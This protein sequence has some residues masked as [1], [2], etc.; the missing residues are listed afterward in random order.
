M[1]VPKSAL[2]AVDGTQYRFIP[3]SKY[4]FTITTFVPSRFAS[5]KYFVVT[6]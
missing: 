1:S 4:G 3:G 6:G 2:L 5:C